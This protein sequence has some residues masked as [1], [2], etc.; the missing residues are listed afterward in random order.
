M[1][2]FIAAGALGKFKI[3][4]VK[5]NFTRIP[6]FEKFRPGIDFIED[7][8]RIFRILREYRW[9]L[10]VRRRQRYIGEILHARSWRTPHETAIALA[11]I[12]FP[13]LRRGDDEFA[14]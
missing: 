9:I 8:C 2:Q 13:T 12:A 1:A 11:R 7:Q 14:D 4:Q 3:A 10:R 5:R 6:E